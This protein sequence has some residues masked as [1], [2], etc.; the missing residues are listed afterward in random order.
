[1]RILIVG[2]GIAGMTLAALLA[3]RGATAELIDRAPDFEHEGYML[4]LYPLGNRVLHGLGLYDR[5]LA[6]SQEMHVYRVCN[7]R[8]E[9]VHEYDI[10]PIVEQLGAVQLLTRG[11]LLSLL[12]EAAADLPLAMNTIV[13]SLEQH[14][15]H[16][17]VTLS[18][19]RSGRYDLVVGADGIHSRMRRDL[20]GE[21]PAHDTG[22][23]GWV[24]W[25]G[26]DE[27]PHD[28]VTE[29]WGAG[30]FLGIY[31]T[32]TR[33]GCVAGGPV[34]KGHKPRDS[35]AA[36]VRE[37]FSDLAGAVPGLLDRLSDDRDV[38]FWPLLDVRSAEWVKGRVVLLG[39]SGA[40]FLPTAGVGAS[41]AMESAA[42]LNDELSR[43]SSRYVTNA[44]DTYV[45]RHRKRVLAAQEESRK[46]AR[47]MF[48]ESTPLAWGRNQLMKFYTLEMLLK[49]IT[50]QMSEPI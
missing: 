17:D 32:R 49:N 46:L 25:L 36:Y 11:E 41:M 30:R 10:T 24:F 44:L 8:G 40:A 48:V 18:D 45:K 33:I 47:M 16:V 26:R 27:V 19:G 6:V 7:G 1:M 42:A 13:T 43:T 20:F 3:R 23:G 12:R 34:P 29:Y 39:D 14:D 5:F 15:D 2:A 35:P 50:R 31:P 37:H 4:G 38:F 28:T 21:Q 22:W 9:L